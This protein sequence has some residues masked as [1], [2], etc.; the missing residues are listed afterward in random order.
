MER[1]E[2]QVMQVFIYFSVQRSLGFVFSEGARE[3][4]VSRILSPSVEMNDRH[5]SQSRG[6][7]NCENEVQESR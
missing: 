1:G 7:R 4:S 2:S 3:R 5:S 6:W